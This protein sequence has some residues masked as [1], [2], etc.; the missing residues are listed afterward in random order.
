MLC[1]AVWGC[2]WKFFALFVDIFSLCILTFS[3]MS[4]RFHSTMLSIA[5]RLLTLDLWCL[6]I[7][8]MILGM[9]HE[10]IS[11]SYF[12]QTILPIL[13]FGLLPS[14]PKMV[15][16]GHDRYSCRQWWPTATKS[17]PGYRKKVSQHKKW[18]SVRS[19]C[20][21]GKRERV[22]MFSCICLFINFSSYFRLV[23]D[24][25]ATVCDCGTPWT[26]HL[27]FWMGFSPNR[28]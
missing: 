13:M 10:L 8:I 27:I 17:I 23:S 11:P 18:R 4:F 14:V 15:A 7:F 20:R 19:G 12:Q 28:M 5:S 26:F 6:V 9:K 2:L 21:L 16:T 3:R 1:G 24:G 22:L 25:F